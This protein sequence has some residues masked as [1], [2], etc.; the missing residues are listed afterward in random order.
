LAEVGRLYFVQRRSRKPLGDLEA[1]FE[2]RG[3][4]YAP[5]DSQTTVTKYG[6]ERTFSRDGRK[7]RFER[8]LTLGG[9]DRQNCLQVYFEFREA[10]DLIDVGY[11]GV[12]LPYEGMRS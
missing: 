5:S 4:K 12:H 2:E 11:C 1:L 9:G 7:V 3:Y 10:A 6:R 8:H